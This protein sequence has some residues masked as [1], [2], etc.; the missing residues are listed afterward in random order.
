M[1]PPDVIP[2]DARAWP[3]ANQRYLMARLSAVREAL[4]RHAGQSVAP[5]NVEDAA[6]NLSGPFAVDSLSSVFGLTPFERDILL[7]CAGAD[8]DSGFGALC[9]ASRGDSRPTF[10]LALAALPEPH[11]SALLPSA[12]LRYWHLIEVAGE[13][14][15]QA[16][17]RIDERILHYLTGV[18]Y[19]DARLEGL[20]RPVEAPSALTPSLRRSADKIAALCSAEHS[21]GSPV[22]QLTGN[23]P[24]ES[25]MVAAAG[26]AA[27]GLRLY[28]MNAA[29]IPCSADREL[30]ARLWD[31]ECALNRAA[32]LIEWDEPD[33][34]RAT[35]AFADAIRGITLIAGRDPVALKR[36]RVLRVDV[37]RPD[38]T[39]QREI[40]ERTLGQ[41]A[42]LNGAL[43]QVVALNQVIAQFHLGERDI[44]AAGAD[45]RTRAGGEI[46]AN[47]WDACRLQ[48]RTRIEGLAQRITSAPAWEDLVLPDSQVQTLREIAQQVRHRP[49]VYEAWGFASR[50]ARGLGI[51]A[52]FFGQSGTGKTMAAEVIATDLHV[53]LYRID[54]SQVVSKYIGETEKNL[55]KVFDAAEESGA[56][57]LFDEADALFG[58]RSEVKDSHDRYANIE[59]SYLLQRM[60][61][62]RGLAILTTNMKTLLDPAFLRRIR[63]AVQFPFPETVHRVRIWS[64]VFPPGTP[65]D[66]LDLDKLARLTMAGGNIRNIAIQSAFL[67]AADG[68]PVRMRHLLRSARSE[69]AKLERPLT[70]AECRGWV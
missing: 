41:A 24:A 1:I 40:W 16:P 36:R 31:R 66:G 49:T 13:T 15:T 62:Y 4:A 3:E 30:I 34:R 22:I 32:L 52:L 70:D 67:A 8:L 25:M 50:G 17:L 63:F 23:A 68:E 45:A 61:A 12:P 20:V 65:T 11:W 51:S 54:L 59:I 58:R 5:V 18:S 19:L 56:V 47:L 37:E 69:C 27:L 43:N 29:D 39:E 35:S 26:C 9:A 2:P 44:E 10:G 55:Q 57:L 46:A 53:D 21:G 64:R 14:L 60:E 7:L 38:A 6:A 33:Q 42:Q 28:A 48:A